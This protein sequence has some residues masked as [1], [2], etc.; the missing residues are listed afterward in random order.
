MTVVPD[1]GERLVGRTT[2]L[3][4]AKAASRRR[5][6]E[7]SPETISDLAAPLVVGDPLV[8]L[9]AAMLGDRYVDRYAAARMLGEDLGA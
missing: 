8:Q 3:A 7:L 4:A 1:L 9:A 6:M 2:L 5:L